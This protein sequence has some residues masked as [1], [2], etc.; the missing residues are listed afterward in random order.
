[1]TR[2][3]AVTRMRRKLAFNNSLNATVL[4]D[5][6]KDAQLSLEKE[7]ELPYFLRTEYT[8]I[9]TV[10]SEERIPLPALPDAPEFLMI[11][12]DSALWRFDST[13]DKQWKEIVKCDLDALR[14]L[15]AESDED[16]PRAYALDGLYFRVFP[17][18]DK[19]YTLKMIYYGKDLLLDTNIENE[20]LK[21]FPFLLIS[22]AIKEVTEGTRDTSAYNL[23][24]ARETVERARLRTFVIARE[25]SNLTYQMGGAE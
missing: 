18:P 11:V 4:V 21:H 15:Y 7:P 25:T 10:A 8:S 3:E 14:R 5:A 9:S 12:E 1:M 24:G 6:L 19:A 17:A 23:A 13:E 2:D 22:L 16:E 20:W